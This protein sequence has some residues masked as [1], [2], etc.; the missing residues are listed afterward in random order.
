MGYTSTLTHRFT[1]REEL[2][3]LFSVDA[4]DYRIDDAAEDSLEE[5]VDQSTY[6]AKAILNKI[7]EDS[8]LSNNLWVRRRT[9]I[10]GCYLLSIRRGNDS[11]YAAEYYNALADMQDLVDGRLYLPDLPRGT[12]HVVVGINVNS[13]NRTP[14][15]PMRVD[16]ASATSLQGVNFIQRYRPFMWL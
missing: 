3:R 10:I 12:A 11:Q 8:D 2:E 6:E 14:L 15:T 7:F 9:T 13:D 1:S 5:I 16:W 4:I